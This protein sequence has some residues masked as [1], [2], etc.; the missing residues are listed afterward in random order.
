MYEGDG[1]KSYV[2]VSEHDAPRA[3]RGDQSGDEAAR[4]ARPTEG[5]VRLEAA[6]LLAELGQ[7][8]VDRAGEQP[9]R[10]LVAAG[11][12]LVGTNNRV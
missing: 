2:A 3:Q 1:D 10:Q 8:G 6:G 5:G 11:G 12:R 4:E 7:P 9:L